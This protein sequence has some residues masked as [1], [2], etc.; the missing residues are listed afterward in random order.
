MRPQKNQKAF[1]II[2]IGVGSMFTSMAIAGFLVGFA[3]D[4][5]LDTLPLGLLIGGLLGFVGGA[6]KVMAMINLVDKH[7]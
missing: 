4:W 6:I 3:V 1:N 7:D 5:I 2:E